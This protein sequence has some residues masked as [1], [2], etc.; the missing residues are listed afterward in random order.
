MG[1]GWL[2]KAGQIALQAQSIVTGIAPIVKAV[3]PGA[4]G[5]IER[6]SEDSQKIASIIQQIEVV[7][8]TLSLPGVDKLKAA[9]PLVAQIMLQSAMLGGKK[10]ENQA[11][12]LSGCQKVA[13]GYADILNSVDAD[14]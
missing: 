6:V 12:F 11:L 7:G 9:T 5:I 10:I 14:A 3:H 1:I 2:K 8:Q 4:G 13:D